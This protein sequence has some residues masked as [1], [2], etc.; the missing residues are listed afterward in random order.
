[1]NSSTRVQKSRDHGNVLRD[2]GILPQRW[3]FRPEAIEGQ[4]E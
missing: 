2:N 1:M 4:S 3:V